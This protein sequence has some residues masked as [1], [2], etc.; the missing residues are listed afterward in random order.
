MK[1]SSLFI[2]LI[3][4]SLGLSAQYKSGALVAESVQNMGYDYRIQDSLSV[5]VYE[6]FGNIYNHSYDERS[7]SFILSLRDSTRNRNPEKRKLSSFGIVEKFD[8]NTKKIP[9]YI[10]TNY[11]MF[12][13]IISAQSIVHDKGD[14]SHIID[15]ETGKASQGLSNDYYYLDRK[16]G[17]GLMYKKVSPNKTF[18]GINI[19][20]ESILWKRQIERDFLTDI[21][22]ISDSNVLVISAGMHLVNI[23]TGNG[24]SINSEEGQRNYSKFIL[25]NAIGIA[26]GI[27]TGGYY[28]DG[29]Y[30]VTLPHGSDLLLNDKEIIKVS[31]D[32]ISNID[33]KSGQVKWVS[34]KIKN[35]S[36]SSHSFKLL[37]DT[38]LAVFDQNYSSEKENTGVLSAPLFATYDIQSGAL[39]SYQKLDL[40][41]VQ[42]YHWFDEGVIVNT[43]SEVHKYSAFDST[44][45][46]LDMASIGCPN[47]VNFFDGDL[48]RFENGSY[49]DVGAYDL[50]KYLVEC[51]NGIVLGLDS[52]LSFVKNYHEDK[53]VKLE[54][55]G[56]KGFYCLQN[57]KSTSII[58]RDGFPVVRIPLS[59]V[60]FMNDSTYYM[61]GENKIKILSI[62][63][64]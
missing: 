33:L 4:I 25:L 9:W 46:K 62:T 45:T 57:E 34:P 1:T 23:Y 12:D 16:S 10:S 19:V 27:L 47:I 7:N 42:G 17:I 21:I 24:W 44:V 52:N 8:L 18:Q 2:L 26:S 55:I 51:E 56:Q 6:F 29:D 63:D 31:L 38:V 32:S 37:K 48:H 40:K 39:S 54:P 13:L 28:F 61:V 35:L 53:L 20:D 43:N 59:D 50:S 15:F 30:Q 58:D 3:L 41:N 11:E 49:K 36:P 5:D 64:E 14:K 22:P 60:Y